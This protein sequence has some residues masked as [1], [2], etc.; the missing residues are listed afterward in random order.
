MTRSEL[1]STEYNE[2]YAKYIDK[3]DLK[4]DLNNGFEDDKKMVIDFFSSVPKEKLDYR[5]QPEKWSIKEILQHLID[6]ER[7]FMYR[8]LRIARKDTTALAGFDQDIFIESSKANAKTLEA[9]LREFTITRLYSINLL[10]SISDENLQNMGTASNSAVSA[11]A[12]AFILLGH[13]I[14][15]I[16][17]IKERYI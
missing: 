11:R 1:N 5:Y 9:L 10:Q 4:T 14:W 15:H 13:S 3:I 8:L 7:I 17:I 12:C 2:Y 16:N 6:T